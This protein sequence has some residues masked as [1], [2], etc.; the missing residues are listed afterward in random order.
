MPRTF[1]IERYPY[2]EDV[3]VFTKT[4][5]TINEGLTVFVGCNGSGKTTLM[6]EI[7]SKLKKDNIP[8]FSFNNLSQGG[9]NSVSE[10]IYGDNIHAAAA[11]MSSSEGESISVNLSI[12]ANLLREFIETGVVNDRSNR[13][14]EAFRKL[15]DKKEEKPAI[16]NE[17]WIFFD[18]VDSGYSID[19]ILD[20]KDFL[21]IIQDHAKRLDLS[22][23]IIV[24]ANAYETAAKEPC[25]D[26]MTMKYKEFRTYEGYKNYILKTREAK[27]KRNGSAEQET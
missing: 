25:L 4:K 22:L 20:F 1:K 24:A 6:E 26:L 12:K 2:D 21:H 23:Y 7:M 3:K 11:L 19:N 5:V 17:R 10:L 16:P 13:F 14:A 27:E 18:A 8:C 9:T 15:V